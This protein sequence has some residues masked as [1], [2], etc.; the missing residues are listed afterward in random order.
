M[1]ISTFLGLKLLFICIFCICTYSLQAQTK[2]HFRILENGVEVQNTPYHLAVAEM[3]LEAFRYIET[4]RQM[5][6][7][8]TNY[9][10]ELF[11]GEELWATYQKRI[12]PFNISAA[13]D[14]FTH[15]HFIPYPDGRVK[16]VVE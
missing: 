4:R 15:T 8:G 14:V 6:I 1:K 16:P 10:I 13:N 9:V 3:N 2:T 7:D 11:S 5:P 12:S